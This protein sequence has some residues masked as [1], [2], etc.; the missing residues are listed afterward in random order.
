MTN[1]I[2]FRDLGILPQFVESLEK[3]KFTIPTPIQAKAIPLGIEG[4]DLIGI[5]QT[6]TGKTLAFGIPMV[7]RLFQQRGIGLVV[8]PT[9]ELATQVE[10]TLFKISHDFAMRTACLIGGASMYNQVQALKRRPKIIV[11]TPGRLIDHIEQ[12]TVLLFDVSMLVLDEAD[13]MFDMGFAP[14]IETIIKSLPVARQTLLF[15]A[16]MPAPIAKLAMQ[17]MQ[18]PISIEVAPQGTAIEKVTQEL[19]VVNP[20]YRKQLLGY[21]IEQ[22][23]NDTILVFT[24]TKITAKVLTRQLNAMGHRAGEIHADRSTSQR[25]EALEGFKRG[26]YRILVATDIA[27]RGIDV[28][29][30]G[31]VINFDLPDEAENYIHRIGRT[32]RAGKG[33]RAISFALPDQTRLVRAIERLMRQQIEVSKHPEVPSAEL[34]LH[35]RPGS[36]R[37]FGGGGGKSFGG[38][39]RSFGGGGGAPRRS[40]GGGERRSFGGEKRTYGDK[41]AFGGGEKKRYGYSRVEPGNETEAP[42]RDYGDKPSYGE[43]R[44]YGPKKFGDKP[45]FGEKRSFGDKP[46]FGGGRRF[47]KPRT[48]GSTSSSSRE[49]Y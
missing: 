16:T 9:R 27:A 43:K 2:S 19:F 32:A 40:F 45:K 44:S 42:K 29:D 21:L 7:Q 37:R 36:G 11:A 13:R 34:E 20:E 5:A 23:I 30:I 14:Q 39:R 47:G 8:V 6:G 33:G 28:K 49:R 26:K 22:N 31:I 46:S 25:R 10:E 24:R 41:P 4:K 15:S 48:E 12:G 18:I 35:E 38:Q 3:L 17:Y 1:Q